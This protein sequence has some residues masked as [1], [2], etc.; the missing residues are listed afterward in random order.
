MK[1]VVIVAMRK[2]DGTADIQPVGFTN[3]ANAGSFIGDIYRK[4]GEDVAVALEVNGQPVE[5]RR[6]RGRLVIDTPM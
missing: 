4:F 5:W 6:E 3:K 1:Y 2:P